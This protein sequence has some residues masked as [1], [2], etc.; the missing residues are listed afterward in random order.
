MPIEEAA[1]PAKDASAAGRV[2]RAPGATLAQKGSWAL[3]GLVAY[4]IFGASI[5]AWE[6]NDLFDTVH[7]LE[8]V[9]AQEEDQLALNHIVSYAI[10]SLNERYFADDLHSAAKERLMQPDLQLMQSVKMG[11][12]VMP[13]FMG[14][15]RDEEILDALQY[16]RMLR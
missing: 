1:E 7:K 16:A 2:R 12:T 8:A 15:L 11:K 13:P 9:H 5:V 3:A 6:R 4:L 10:L 14:I